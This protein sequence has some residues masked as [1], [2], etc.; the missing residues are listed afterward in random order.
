MFNKKILKRQIRKNYPKVI[1]RFGKQLL[2]SNSTNRKINQQDISQQTV[3]VSYSSATS[4]DIGNVVETYSPGANTETLV[5]NA[6][7]NS[8]DKGLYG[9]DASMQMKDTVDKCTKMLKPHR[10][11]VCKNSP[12]KDGCFGQNNKKMSQLQSLM[13]NWKW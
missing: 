10:A 12:V 4:K 13:S 7:K 6:G 5:I 11:V 9:Q 1:P 2:I 8:I 3:I